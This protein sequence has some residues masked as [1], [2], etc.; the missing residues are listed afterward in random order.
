MEYYELDPCHFYTAPG[1]TWSAALKMTGVELE[2]L[3]NPDMS[4]L[5]DEGMR[6][7]ISQISNRYAKAN[8]PYLRDYD[9]SKE[10]SYIINLDATN[11]YGWAM[12]QYLPAHG[13]RWCSPEEI[14]KLNVES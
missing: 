12:S 10:S 14:M 3:K 5:V 7:G 9:A 1:L 2:L 11:L 6:G 13:F 8:N 4:L